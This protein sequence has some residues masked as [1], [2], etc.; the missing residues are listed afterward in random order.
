[1]GIQLRRLVNI[2]IS[3]WFEVNYS[4]FVLHIILCLFST[5]SFNIKF[6]PSNGTVPRDI[7]FFFLSQCVSN[8]STKNRP[9][10]G[11]SNPHPQFYQ[12]NKRNLSYFL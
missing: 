2:E 1:M 8:L 6:E 5:A 4:Y 9:I 11:N 10:M 12:I 3:H 7:K